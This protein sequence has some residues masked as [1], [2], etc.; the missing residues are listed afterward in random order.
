MIRAFKLQQFSA[1]G[2]PL[3]MDL[4]ETFITETLFEWNDMKNVETLIIGRMTKLSLAG[5]NILLQKCPKLK[6]LGNLGLWG[7]VSPPDK[8]SFKNELRARNYDIQ[9]C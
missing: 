6:K 1:V 7:K 8:E 3:N 9:I 4:S 2:A 5:A